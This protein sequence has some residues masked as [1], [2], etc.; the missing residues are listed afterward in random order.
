M[1]YRIK[2]SVSNDLW[3]KDNKANRGKSPLDFSVACGYKTDHN[4]H[5][6]PLVKVL[7]GRTR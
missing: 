5:A 4:K 6:S 7:A 3:S 2:T 1:R